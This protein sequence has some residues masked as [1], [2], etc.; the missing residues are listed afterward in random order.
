MG[1]VS[2]FK[3]AED[4]EQVEEPANNTNSGNEQQ[5]GYSQPKNTYAPSKRLMRDKK[6][7]ILGGVCAGLANYF[8][9]DALWIRLIFALLTFVYGVTFFV[10]IVMWILVPGSD[11]L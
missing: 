6:R 4:Q 9:I 8:N 7:K 10:Y 11:D 5:T 2:D 1:S 3:A